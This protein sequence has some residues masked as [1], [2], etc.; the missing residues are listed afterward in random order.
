MSIYE[1]WLNLPH[2]Q[3]LKSALAPWHCFPSSSTILKP[4]LPSPVSSSSFWHSNIGVKQSLF[5]FLC[6]CCPWTIP[7]PHANFHANEFWI[8][9]STQTFSELSIH[10]FFLTGWKFYFIFIYL[11]IYLWLHWVF[12]AARGLSL[13]AVSGGYS[14]LWCPGFSLQWLLLLQSTG[15][16]HTSFSSCGTWAQ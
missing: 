15:S 5:C 11:F 8:S 1:Q 4:F 14:S 3:A 12:I 13:V 2:K 16:R 6:I 7:A 10:I 9:T